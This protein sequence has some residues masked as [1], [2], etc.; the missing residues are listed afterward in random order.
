[1]L[2]PPRADSDSQPR[3]G[4]PSRHLPY[5]QVSHTEPTPPS[6]DQSYAPESKQLRPAL[7]PDPLLGVEPMPCGAALKLRR[8]SHS[9]A[10]EMILDSECPAAPGSPCVG[11][12]GRPTLDRHGNLCGNTCPLLYRH[13]VAARV[14]GNGGTRRQIPELHAFMCGH[15][16]A[17]NFGV[18]GVL[19]TEAFPKEYR[20]NIPLK[21]AIDFETLQAVARATEGE[22]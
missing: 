17:T 5:P 15:A 8:P 12:H 13:V 21:P 18:I 14:V 20:Q 2:T 10:E 11:R 4:P 7:R 9:T 16:D 22:E 19:K 6:G 3:N 1:M